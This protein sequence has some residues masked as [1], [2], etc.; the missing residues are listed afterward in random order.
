M[1]TRR[2][3]WLRGA[4]VIGLLLCGAYLCRGVIL[5][6][7][8]RLLIVDQVTASFQT[9]ALWISRGEG[10]AME[11]ARWYAAGRVRQVLLL[12]PPPSRL[13]RWGL[14]APDFSRT[15]LIRLGVPEESLV[16]VAHD[17]SDDWRAAEELGRWLEQHPNADL[18]VFC[19]LFNSRRV[20]FILDSVLPRDSAQS[21]KLKAL[22]PRRYDAGNWWKQPEGQ[23]EFIQAVARLAHVHVYG[24][25]TAEG[26]EADLDLF[27]SSIKNHAARLP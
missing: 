6:A 27:A 14:L 8:A 10:G 2:R 12:Q 5:Q 24:R 3:R 25:E 1:S 18:V 11:A 16:M 17:V 19:D 13:Q 7:A 15:R 9:D 21:V 26:R 22:Q 20:R 23:L 4:I